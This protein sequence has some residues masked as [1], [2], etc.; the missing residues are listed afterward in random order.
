M[1]L[2]D[3]LPPLEPAHEPAPPD[4]GHLRRFARRLEFDRAVF[5]ALAARA[6]QTLAGPVTVIL[7][8]TRFTPEMQGHYYAF[9]SLLAIQSLFELSLNV[10]LLN[11]AGHEW[12]F[13]RLDERGRVAGEDHAANRLAGLL[14]FGTR[15]Y[16]AA[17]LLGLVVIGGTGHVLFATRGLSLSGHFAW[18]ATV[19]A[20]SV[21]LALLPRIAI[22]QGC[23]QVLAVNRNAVIQAISGTLAVW[24]C[25]VA[26][27]G[28]WA[29]AASWIARLV[30][31]LRLVIGRY[32]TFFDSLQ[33]RK[34]PHVRWAAEIWP[35][36]WRLAL[37]AIAAAA[38]TSSFVL[39]LYV[40]RPPA[41]REVEAGRMGM[42]LSV[43]NMLL[44]SG[45]AWFQ[46][47]I[48][49]LAGY[50]RRK[51]RTEYDRLFRRV[52]AATSVVVIGGA[53]AFWC[54]IAGMDA[55]G[56][57]LAERFLEPLPLALLAAAI[58]TQHF[59]NCLTIYARTRQR[60]PFLVAN[61][62]LNFTIAAG[63]WLAAPALGELGVAAVY[64]AVVVVAGIPL[65]VVIWNRDR[66]E[67]SLS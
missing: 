17:A 33:R 22:L 10:V 49:V 27:L 31:E 19:V 2:A 37:Q 47:R 53:V 55:L 32:G 39:A 28:L 48:P 38:M 66:Q 43:L 20:S 1:S 4:R 44:W 59:L 40:A 14:R 12:P 50:S 52:A 60:E 62:T 67:W 9:G 35:L 8:A 46:T 54:V 36:Q 15:W 58:A 61:V 64:A 7:I 23:H 13:L 34:V 24:G 57:S 51:A 63:V 30:W 25:I 3:D 18:T 16:A 21:M 5:Y 56:V 6:W 45:L 11:A 65:W 26:G 29:V 41:L 42:T